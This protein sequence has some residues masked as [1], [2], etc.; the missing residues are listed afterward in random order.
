[1][2]KIIS[3]ILIIL[4]MG[5]MFAGCGS[6]GKDKDGN[7]Q[8]AEIKSSDSSVETPTEAKEV[9]EKSGTEINVSMGQ[10]D[11]N[12][13]LP[14]GYPKDVI[15]LLEDA[16]IVNVNDARDTISKAIGI[17]YMT[18]KSLEDTITFYQEVMKDGTI[19]MENKTDDTFIIMGRKGD[20][21]VTISGAITNDTVAI[22]LDVAP[23][24]R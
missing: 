1:M 9:E 17:G 22:M 13:S 10:A 7:S 5:I 19:D 20:Y 3:V 18:N 16:N 4:L 6:A 11:N 14:D 12:M 2:K 21:V 24:N 8:D 15:P 23:K